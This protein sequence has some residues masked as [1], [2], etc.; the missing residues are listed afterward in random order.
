MDSLLRPRAVRHGGARHSC[1]MAALLCCLLALAANAQD[2]KLT[3]YTPHTSASLPLA[4]LDGKDYVAIADVLQSLGTVT[5]Q[6]EGATLKLRFTGAG[7]GLEAQFTDGRTTCR[8]CG[9]TVELTSRFVLQA[10]R[11][12]LPVRS[13]PAVL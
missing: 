6:V 11:G 8:V 3:I 12:L 1:R 5:A 13:L 4:E 9:G 10:G 7:S 2:K